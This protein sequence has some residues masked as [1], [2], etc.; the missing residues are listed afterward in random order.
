LS[1]VLNLYHESHVNLGILMMLWWQSDAIPTPVPGTPL[2]PEFVNTKLLHMCGKHATTVTEAASKPTMYCT[3]TF[4][5]RYLVAASICLQSPQSRLLAGC[6]HRLPD[7]PIDPFLMQIQTSSKSDQ[8]K[9]VL[10]REGW[11]LRALLA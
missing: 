7:H 1:G 11:C 8:T 2:I 10:G 6:L 3:D 9:K 4:E 5:F